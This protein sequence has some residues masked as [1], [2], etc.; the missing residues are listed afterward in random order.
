[1]STI[2][3][4]KF[5]NSGIPLI[6]LTKNQ[7][8]QI[9]DEAIKLANKELEKEN[10]VLFFKN[11]VPVDPVTTTIDFKRNILLGIK[12]G[13]QEEPIDI[14][15]IKALDEV[16]IKPK[17][18]LAEE[19]IQKVRQHLLAKKTEGI[20]ISSSGSKFDTRKLQN[21][22]FEI[23]A[24]GYARIDDKRI[25]TPTQ[26]GQWVLKAQSLRSYTILRLV[27]DDQKVRLFDDYDLVRQN[28]KGMFVE[29]AKVNKFALSEI[30]E[31]ARKDA[32]IYEG[33]YLSLGRDEMT[34][35][36]KNRLTEVLLGVL[37][38]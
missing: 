37:S 19:M 9:F 2:T 4:N 18:A 29:P 36:L 12:I 25:V 22:T 20:A 16:S 32:E 7:H 33:G 13:E 15:D 27:E 31:G 1:M 11:Q 3:L 38:L 30:E 26:N 17:D 8:Q 35:D 5:I 6:E 34:Q 21:H 14:I 10:A 24:Q 23:D 28:N